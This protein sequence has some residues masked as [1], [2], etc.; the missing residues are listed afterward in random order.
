[1]VEKEFFETE[2]IR[3]NILINSFVVMP[4][5]IH[6]IIKI[7]IPYLVGVCRRQTPTKKQWNGLQKNSLG[8]IINQ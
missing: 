3:K 4:N 7:E 8:A 2:K 6:G 5:H 1:M